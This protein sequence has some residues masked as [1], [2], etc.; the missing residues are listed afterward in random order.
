MKFRNIVLISLGALVL[1]FILYQ[2][3]FVHEKVEVQKLE[4]G[5][6]TSVIYATGNV[7]ADTMAVLRSETEGIVKYVGPLAGA[8]VKKGD[9]LLKADQGD[10][11]L[12]VQQAESALKTTEVEL[13]TAETNYNRNKNLMESNT[14]TKKEFDD[15]KRIYD[16][17]ELKVNQAKITLNISKENL[18]KTIIYA[19]FSGI[20]VSVTVKL[21]DNLTPNSECFQI[22]S[23][24]SLVVRGEVDEQDLPKIN[25]NQECVVAFDAY[26]DEKFDGYI[27]RIV[28]K[29]DEATK[30]SKVFIKI[31]NLPKHL[32]VGMTATINIA[33]GTKKNVLLIPRTSIVSEGINKYVFI[34]K[35]NKLQKVKVEVGN[36]VSGKFTNLINGNLQRGTELVLNPKGNFESGMKVVAIEK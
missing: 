16:L 35:N 32:N 9:L 3:F 2:S 14:I 17:A 24:T 8:M 5:N 19:P 22:V 34:S 23:P 1:I 27:S 13:S 36:N 33:A 21:G 31:K 28:P 15:A 29:T 4:R 11:L 6:L 18:S 25:L 26:P 10:E 7:T 12:R 20:I 30:T